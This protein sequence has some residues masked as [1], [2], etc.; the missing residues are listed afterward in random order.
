MKNRLLTLTI[1][2]ITQLLFWLVALK[3]SIV[4]GSE[5]FTIT[6][7][8]GIFLAF[9][10]VGHR[11]AKWVAIVIMGL[12]AVLAVS[13][14]FEGFGWGFLIVAAL[15]LALIVSLFG[16]SPEDISSAQAEDAVTAPDDHAIPV[17]PGEF[18]AGEKVYQ[19]PLLLRRY[20]ALFIDGLIFLIAVTAAL[21]I[22]D[23]TQASNIL[24][25]VVAFLFPLVYEPI[26]TCYSSTIGQRLLGIRVRDMNNPEKRINLL[27]AYIRSVAKGL[28]GWLSFITINFNPEH[29]AIHDFASS[30]V[31]IRV[32]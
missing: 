6:L 27:Q 15:Y 3:D 29:R 11:W 25:F 1:F 22:V 12:L 2:A 21:V 7:I 28:L 19:Y 14:T 10:W 17:A 4:F 18:V 16:W 24:P 8:I 31:V 23:E 30:S 32:R 26:L 13:M 9:Y 5:V 20:Q